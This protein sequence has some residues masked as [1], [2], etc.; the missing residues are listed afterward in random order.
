MKRG[1]DMYKKILSVILVAVLLLSLT[2]CGEK[3]IL[4]CDRCGVEVNVDADS[5][6]DEDWAIF[7]NECNEEIF[8][9]MDITNAVE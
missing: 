4:H 7:C 5:N 9:D 3:K 8:H 6:M 2:A 1:V